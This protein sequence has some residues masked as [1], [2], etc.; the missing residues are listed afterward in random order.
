MQSVCDLIMIRWRSTIVATRQVSHATGDIMTDTRR[1]R[2]HS[3]SSLLSVILRHNLNQHPDLKS[4]HSISAE[5]FEI[6]PQHLNVIL[7]NHLTTSQRH[8]SRSPHSISTSYF[9]ITPQPLNVILRDHPLH[10][11]VILWYHPRAL[12]AQASLVADEKGQQKPT[13][14]PTYVFTH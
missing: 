1:Q 11:H 8:T 10:F 12:D 5:Y 2:H 4:S 7:R 6:T 13:P 9:E 3:A 14:G